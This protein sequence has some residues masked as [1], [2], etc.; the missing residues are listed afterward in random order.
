MDT[1]AERVSLLAVNCFK[2]VLTV[3]M[4]AV[5]ILLR[6][7]FI[8]KALNIQSSIEEIFISPASDCVSFCCVGIMGVGDVP[9]NGEAGGGNLD[10]QHQ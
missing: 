6:G 3:G 1:I 8:L 9:G 2:N 4:T 5:R 7:S 10:Y